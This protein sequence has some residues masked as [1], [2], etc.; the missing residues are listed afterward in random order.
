MKR[1]THILAWTLLAMVAASPPVNAAEIVLVNG[2]RVTGKF[3]RLSEGELVIETDYAG[4]ISIA[5]EKVRR[6]VTDEP[7]EV[8]LEDGTTTRGSI[9]IREETTEGGQVQA[10]A[11]EQAIGI[12][13]VKNLYTGTRPPIRIKSSANIGITRENGNTDTAQYALAAEVIARMEKIRLTI[14]GEFNRQKENN[15]TTAANWNGYGMYDYFLKP[16]WFLYASSLFEHDEFADLNLRTTLGAG[17]G[18]QFFESDELN[19]SA[20]AGLA[21]VFEDYIA[22]D[23]DSFPGGQ[24]I[25]RYDQFFFDQAVQLFHSNNGYVSLEDASNWLI[26]TRQGLRFPL[27]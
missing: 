15:V 9:F 2:D 21:Y 25:V 22:A 19:L 1:Y 8:K 6:L 27:A 17:A 26:N 20:S 13:R 23:D 16:K 18:H 12:A 7:A 5:V 24:W 10:E 14:G 11:T 4:E 3:V